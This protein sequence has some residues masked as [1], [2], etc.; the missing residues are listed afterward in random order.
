MHI[1]VPNDD[2]ARIVPAL[3]SLLQDE[4]R[5]IN[6]DIREVC[7]DPQPYQPGRAFVCRNDGYISTIYGI[8]GLDCQSLFIVKGNTSI[9][10]AA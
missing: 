3:V 5:R 7:L 10:S 6:P 2:R 1:E 8:T 4:L 9:A